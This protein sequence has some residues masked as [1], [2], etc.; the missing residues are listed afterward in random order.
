MA[1]TELQKFMASKKASTGSTLGSKI[2]NAKLRLS[3]AG[4]TKDTRNA[5]E[6][7]LNLREDQN[8]L[9][10]IA[11]VIGRPQQAIFSAI[12]AS[13]EGNDVGASAM[14]G[15]SGN[16]YTNAG[17][18]LRN[19]GM[20]DSGGA[21]GMDDVLGTAIDL[22]ADPIA[23]P[24]APVKAVGGGIKFTS[25]LD[26]AAKG[27]VKGVKGGAKLTDKAIEFGL[28]KADNAKGI[29]YTDGIRNI[30]KDNQ[31]FSGKLESYKGLKNDINTNFN[32]RN[33]SKANLVGRVASVEDNADF[34]KNIAGLEVKKLDDNIKVFAKQTGSTV[35][36][37]NQDFKVLAATAA[38]KETFMGN[39]LESKKYVNIED[40][41]L[42]NVL[43]ILKE[44]NITDF[45]ISRTGKGI[46]VN[47]VPKELKVQPD[48]LDKLNN[49]I[50][51]TKDVTDPAV[52][53]RADEIMQN[54]T[55][56]KFY[57]DNH[58]DK[59]HAN[60][61]RIFEEGTG[62]KIPTTKGYDRNSLE[63]KRRSGKDKAFITKKGAD[64][65]TEN[66]KTRKLKE[67]NEAN[68]NKVKEKHISN[69]SDVKIARVDEQI[70]AQEAKIAAQ[71][72]RLSKSL[73]KRGAGTKKLY[74]EVIE[75]E[76]GRI[77]IDDI[78]SNKIYKKFQKLVPGKELDDMLDYATKIGKKEKEYEVLLKKLDNVGLNDKD[79]D[80]I[81]D[82][83]KMRQS[84]LIT[85]S[86][87]MAKKIDAMDV[88]VN[89][90]MVDTLK[91]ATK[92]ADDV[93]K[94]SN[95]VKRVETKLTSYKE[96]TKIIR[97]NINDSM[98]KSKANLKYLNNKR[99]MIANNPKRA[100]ED[101]AIKD[102]IKDIE[103]QITLLD[104]DYAA[105]LFTESY[106]ESF[107]DFIEKTTEQV[108]AKGILNEVLLS[109]TFND[110][111]LF[112][113]ISNRSKQV[114]KGMVAVESE[115]MIK[116]FDTW[117]GIVEDTGLDAFKTLVKD[118][119]VYMTPE[120][121]E[122]MFKTVTNKEAHDFIKI[123]GFTNNAFKKLKTLSLGFQMRN[124]IGN[125]V[126][127]WLSGMPLG[128]MQAYQA[129][130]LGVWNKTNN[131]LEKVSLG[132]KL[133][134]EEAKTFALLQRFADSGLYKTGVKVMDLEEIIKTSKNGKNL[135]KKAYDKVFEF[136]AEVNS[137]V[138]GL[139]RL[140]LFM[141]A[142]KSPKYV[143][144]LGVTNAGEAVRKV[145][146]DPNNMSPFEKKTMKK[147]IPFYTF[148]KQ[149]LFYQ[150]DNIARN[151]VKYNRLI[152]AN[153]MTWDAQFDEDEYMR[154]QKEGFQ[155]PLP[156]N[157][158]NGNPILMKL[159]LP[160]S[161][162]GEYVSNPGQRLMSSTTPF[163]RAPV[164]AVMKKEFFTGRD[165]TLEGMAGLDFIAK[166]TGLDLFSK[167]VPKVNNLMALENANGV[168]YLNTIAPSVSTVVNREKNIT[169]NQYTD[170]E[171]LNAYIKKLKDA[172]VAVRDVD[173]IK[174]TAQQ[175][176]NRIKR[177]RKKNATY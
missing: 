154:Y 77:R 152:R 111:S 67:T 66:A 53:A 91:S 80:L 148:T 95:E 90:T 72:A 56:M 38:P 101:L 117:G 144:K 160:L 63:I 92:Y 62:V 20:K 147:I 156:I 59:M 39:I 132:A 48:K 177:A 150:I 61:S 106:S 158:S 60:I 162:L 139:N 86:E 98:I 121:H 129:K 16:D 2:A 102:A 58:P 157:D 119:K 57:N 123:V 28:K 74:K 141:Y 88:R 124:G 19:A 76:A 140:A 85:K 23:I 64:T 161:D 22:L 12:K 172:G 69:L 68:L 25:A 35:E 52:L 83:I 75:K 41:E 13:Q 93:A 17:T 14:E 36:K 126:N 30:T 89:N 45:N 118:S 155:V 73:G 51:K 44:N 103:K 5:L 87:Q 107:V 122:L 168:D 145:L 110:P 65:F 43:K 159:N 100:L 138:D 169:S 94:N 130:S 37:V 24:L 50:I 104:N 136:N 113:V 55:F 78:F 165:I 42:P 99:A 151:P 164:E 21:I 8:V 120:I 7:L 54:P 149:N 108:K 1:Q 70:I 105:K 137:Y 81:L 27:A 84:E 127:M 134:A 131:I 166:N 26:I 18:L 174:E 32:Y 173:K 171:E 133:T 167:T 33:S 47:K 71:E 175:R 125:P 34:Y 15:L 46:R 49:I 109:E 135:P 143:S 146:F 128:Q 97:S 112:Q 10:D 82:K 29:T 114:P 11:E 3:D 31:M 79:Y 163:L 142:E 9:F 6:K 176:L 96:T 40:A 153:N 116:T 115:T 4:K 170:L